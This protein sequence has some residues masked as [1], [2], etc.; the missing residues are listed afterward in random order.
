DPAPDATVDVALPASAVV[1]SA[2]A[3]Q[4]QLTTAGQ[5]IVAHLGL[6]TR[7]LAP[8]VV[9]SLRATTAGPLTAALRRSGSGAATDITHN[10][11]AAT[12]VVTA[13]T[14][15]A[16]V[17]RTDPKRGPTKI[18][19]NFSGPLDTAGVAATANYRLVSAGKDKKF[20]TKDD[21]VVAIRSASYDPSKSQVTL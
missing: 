9:I 19:V 8:T 16:G 2:G 4:G 15:V 6:V 1:V 10:A 21:Q 12:V 13:P 18:A 3:S 11:V 5:H 14:T 20:G 7:G 17:V